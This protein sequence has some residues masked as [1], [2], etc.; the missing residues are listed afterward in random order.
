M[1]SQIAR[2][3]TD[4][5]SKINEEARGNLEM[6]SYLIAAIG[7]Y[8]VAK[9]AGMA[10][11]QAD[12]E[13]SDSRKKGKDPD[14]WAVT[15]TGIIERYMYVY[16]R[17][18]SIH[19]RHLLLFV[20]PGLRPYADLPILM[21]KE[22][23]SELFE[24]VCDVRVTGAIL[25]KIYTTD[26]AELF[27]SF[28]AAYVSKGSRLEALIPLLRTGDGRVNWPLDG[29][30]GL[31]VARIGDN[32]P[33][34]R[35]QNKMIAGSAWVRIP[36]E[37]IGDDDFATRSLEFT[38]SQS[39]AYIKTAKD[40]H[41][42]IHRFPMLNR[43]LKRAGSDAFKRL[44]D[45][46]GPRKQPRTKA[47]DQVDS[48]FGAAAKAKAKG[49]SKAKGHVQ[50]LVGGRSASSGIGAG[51]TCRGGAGGAASGP[52]APSVEET[53][54]PPSPGPMAEEEAPPRE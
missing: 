32:P 47:D 18:P 17:W 39:C 5:L 27:L 12:D 24:R 4:M 28:C 52:T 1:A 23:V 40:E 7:D 9:A 22:A 8:K 54:D 20:E 34:V 26:R 42:L 48:G 14:S 44:A 41:K 31:T 11:G 2:A 30:Y 50:G 16:K 38:F 6:Q 15:P 19:I 36:E 25:D 45:I 37:E 21:N 33:T 46:G 29:V 13:E 43:Q 10:S 51:S 53:E 49:K 3:G 35:V